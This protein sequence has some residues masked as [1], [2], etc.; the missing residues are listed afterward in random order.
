[1]ASRLAS[2][3]QETPRSSAHSGVAFAEHSVVALIAAA[4]AAELEPFELVLVLADVL[5]RPGCTE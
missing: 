1:M 3:K 5:Q 2:Q 4:V